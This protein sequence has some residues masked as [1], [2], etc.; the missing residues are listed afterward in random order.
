MVE[1]RRI[2]GEHARIGALVQGGPGERGGLG[3]ERIRLFVQF[4]RLFGELRGILRAV[5]C[6]HGQPFGS[7]GQLGS[8]VRQLGS[9]VGQRAS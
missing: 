9:G 7:F 1:R 3:R 5:E 6:S 4:G 2:L 8:L